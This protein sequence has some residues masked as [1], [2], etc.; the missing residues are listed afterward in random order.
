MTTDGFMNFDDMEEIDLGMSN[1]NHEIDDGFEVALRNKPGIAWGRH[2]AWEFNGRVWFD[3]ELFHE[4]IWRY[5]RP[6][7]T[8]SAATLPE[9]MRAANNEFGDG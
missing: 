2:A 3:G 5:C 8:V 9:L 7:V 6:R 4:E 1:F